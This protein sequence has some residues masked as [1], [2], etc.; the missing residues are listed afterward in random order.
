MY[1][2]TMKKHTPK[3]VNKSNKNSNVF[4]VIARPVSGV[5]LLINV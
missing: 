1:A 5:N 3:T 2:A 4:S